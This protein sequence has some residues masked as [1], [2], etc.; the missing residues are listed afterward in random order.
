MAQK[1]YKKSNSKNH[2]EIWAWEETPETIEALK[3][4]HETTIKVNEAKEK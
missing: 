3:K 1:Q 2:E 4:L